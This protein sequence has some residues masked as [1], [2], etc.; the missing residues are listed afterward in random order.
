MSVL[1]SFLIHGHLHLP[2]LVFLLSPP[3]LL[4]LHQ[5][6]QPTGAI[7]YVDSLLQTYL[8][9]FSAAS[10]RNCRLTRKS[11]REFKP[12]V[13]LETKKNPPTTCNLFQ[14]QRA[15]RGVFSERAER[16][17]PPSVNCR[18]NNLVIWLLVISLVNVAPFPFLII[19]TNFRRFC[20]F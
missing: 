1:C 7:L 4:V 2:E 13:R 17:F 6:H 10:I 11:A 20:V 16:A 3:D 12:D 14:S 8:C 19:T 15:S 9:P 5:F 18:C